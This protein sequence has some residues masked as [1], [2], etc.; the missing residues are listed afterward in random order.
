MKIIKCY[1][2]KIKNENNE[3]KFITE[4]TS[5]E[6][7]QQNDYIIIDNICYEIEYRSFYCNEENSCF[8]VSLYLKTIK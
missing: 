4:I 7:P 5:D 6:T 8:V 1:N 2:A 3:S